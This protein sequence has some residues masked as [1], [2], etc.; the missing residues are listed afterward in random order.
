MAKG[1]DD[2]T[3]YLSLSFTLFFPLLPSFFFLVSLG[4][5]IRSVDWAGEAELQW[6]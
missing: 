4:G 3:F 6:A 5:A 2:W 1:K